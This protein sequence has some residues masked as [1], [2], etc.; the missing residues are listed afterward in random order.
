[1]IERVFIREHRRNLSNVEENVNL[2]SH[3]FFFLSFLESRRK[4]EI[5]LWQI[6]KFRVHLHPRQFNNSK[7]TRSDGGGL[8][9]EAGKARPEA[10][11]RCTGSVI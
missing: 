8:G 3:V 2:I 4:V 11:W 9:V 5:I 10:T 7:M 1:M 6:N